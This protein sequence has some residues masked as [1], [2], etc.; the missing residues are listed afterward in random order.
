MAERQRS[1]A[2]S[3]LIKK[4]PGSETAV[5]VVL[6]VSPDH[7]D[8][9]SLQNIFESHWAVIGSA[10]IASALS[11]LRQVPI[12][13]VIYDCEVSPGT[14]GE[15]LDDIS[16]FPDPP[17]LIVTSRLADERLWAEALNLGAW[18]V[19]AKPFDADEVN[20]IVTIAGQ[21]WQDRHGVHSS[22]TKQRKSANGPRSIAAP[23]AW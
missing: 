12:P 9:A 5:Q 22:R 10:T 14:W 17:L 15:M 2:G 21:H 18:D 3:E 19:L 11:V 23:G 16:R 6:S 1:T 7:E 4:P 8:C 20:R 13:I